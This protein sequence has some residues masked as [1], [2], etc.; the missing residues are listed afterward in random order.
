MLSAFAFQWTFDFLDQLINKSTKII[1]QQVLMKP[2]YNKFENCVDWFWLRGENQF[3]FWCLFCKDS[4]LYHL[5]VAAGGGTGN[6]GTEYEQLIAKVM[7][8]NGDPSKSAL[9]HALLQTK[10][11]WKILGWVVSKLGMFSKYSSFF[12]FLDSL[13]WKHPMMLHTKEPLTKPLTTLPSEDLQERALD[14]SRV[15]S[16][17]HTYSLIKISGT[18][19]SRTPCIYW[20]ELEVQTLF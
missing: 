9:I 17:Q 3:D 10:I 4:W 1:I 16:L 2:K 15:S 18:S 8:A 13:Y 20:R 7:E 6:V 5:T 12:S 11:N 19:T 14:L